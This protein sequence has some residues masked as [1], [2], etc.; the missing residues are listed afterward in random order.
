M[1]ARAAGAGSSNRI[2]RSHNDW[3]RSVL[4]QDVAR[5]DALLGLV[6]SIM[7]DAEAK[8]EVGMHPGCHAACIHVRERYPH[9]QHDSTRA[10]SQ[11][12]SPNVDGRGG[13]SITWTLEQSSCYLSG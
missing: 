8:G 7:A 11:T 4:V 5:V 13:S 2:E 6:I 3:F 10:P 12:G 1:Q 9:L